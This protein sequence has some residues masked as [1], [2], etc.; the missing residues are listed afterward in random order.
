M[1]NRTKEA[2]LAAMMVTLFFVSRT[3]SIPVGG[4]L[5]DFSGAIIFTA[6]SVLSWPYTLIF[7]LSTIYR[8]S[9]IFGVIFWFTGTQSVFLLTKLLNKKWSPHIP[10]FG[11]PGGV[12]FYAYAMQIAGF[13]DALVFFASY[14]IPLLISC[15]TTYFGGLLIWGV[16]RRFEVID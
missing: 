11:Q 6:A 3:F 16:L 13:M 10:V 14:G 12:F 7:S 2:A 5:L 9:N 4:F 15:V 1:K 8:G